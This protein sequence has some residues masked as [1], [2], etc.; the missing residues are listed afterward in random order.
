[1]DV[2]PSPIVEAQV[3]SPTQ[4]EVNRSVALPPIPPPA[5][6]ISFVKPKPKP[7]KKKAKS[8]GPV[9]QETKNVAQKPLRSA[10]SVQE[11]N[12]LSIADATGKSAPDQLRKV[13]Y[14][15]YRTFSPV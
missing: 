9:S 15:I 7:S 4:P 14:F 1:M 11:E 12:G 5:P 2:N 3:C 13:T 6:D 8:R 10:T